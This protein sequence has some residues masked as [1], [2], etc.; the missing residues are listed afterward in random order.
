MVGDDHRPAQQVFGS[1]EA[2]DSSKSAERSLLQRVVDRRRSDPASLERSTD[3][4]RDLGPGTEPVGLDRV[5]C[6]R[7]AA[8]A[9]RR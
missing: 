2:V 7:G 4:G 8:R 5:C 3:D 1:S 9:L 6:Y